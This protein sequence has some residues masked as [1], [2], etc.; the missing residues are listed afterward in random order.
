[1][2]V[3]PPCRMN[4]VE[5]LIDDYVRRL[6]CADVVF[7]HGTDNARDAAFRLVVDALDGAPLTVAARRHLDQLLARRIEDREPVPHLTGKA[8]LGDIAFDVRPQMMIPRSPIA[9]VLA[10][11]VEPWLAAAPR[12]ILDLCCGVGALGIL[13]ALVFPDAEVDLVDIDPAALAV[14]RDNARKVGHG[15]AS[16][17]RVIA[18]D[19]FENLGENPRPASAYGCRSEDRGRY[20]LILCNPPYVPTAELDVG[21]PEL[22]HEPEHGLDGGGD[23]L[24][25]WR[26]IVAGLDDQLTESG[27]LVGEVGSVARG[28]DAAFPHLG[29]V[30]L[31]LR[32]AEPQADGGFGVFVATPLLR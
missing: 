30:W 18:S 26:R 31:D 28:F 24:R 20:D 14:A 9:E 11:G 29:A 27:V 6:S 5:A 23:G 19:L 25:V 16:R 12:R 17:T 1:M 2:S 10:A 15:V 22:R 21:P 13:A 32:Q 7:C 4:E 8:W 3:L